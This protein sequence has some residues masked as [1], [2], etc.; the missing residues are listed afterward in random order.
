MGNDGKMKCC[1]Q[2]KRA[3]KAQK[4]WKAQLENLL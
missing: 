3:V 2:L 4:Q 1:F